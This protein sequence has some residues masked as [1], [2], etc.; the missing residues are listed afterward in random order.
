M[1]NKLKVILACAIISF[2]VVL[3]FSILILRSATLENNLK[4]EVNEL[5]DLD[6]TKDRYNA[7]IKTSGKYGKVEET[8]KTYL[9]DYAVSLQ[10]L[11]VDINDDKLTKILS[12]ENYEKDGPEFKESLEYLSTAKSEFNE[13]IDKL[14][15]NS[16]ENSIIS[17]GESKLKNKQ[18]LELYKELMLS[19]QML[20]N[21]KETK[22]TLIETKTRVNNIY[23]TS[24]KVLNFLVKNKANWKLEKGEIKFKTTALYNDYNKMIKEINKK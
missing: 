11:I 1:N 22:E 24:T 7:S 20:N 12:Y 10:S 6:F 8:I 2:D 17:Y 9:D 3:L 16:E 13:N 15:T 19:N 21:F 14:I 4:K 23:D 18:S 5:V